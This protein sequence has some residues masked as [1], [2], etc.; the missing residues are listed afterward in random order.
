MAFDVARFFNDLPF[1]PSDIP[2]VLAEHGTP[3]HALTHYKW[4]DR[5]KMP[6]ERACALLQEAQR[7]GRTLMITDYY[8]APTD[9]SN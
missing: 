9:T 2:K 4:L 7:R 8:N 1:R 3:V 5:G 6:L